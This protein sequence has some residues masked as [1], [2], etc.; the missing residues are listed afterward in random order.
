MLWACH[1]LIC[2]LCLC[3]H[4]HWLQGGLHK[5]LGDVG[6]K[7]TWSNSAWDVWGDNW[8]IAEAEYLCIVLW[9][10]L[11]KRGKVVALT[12]DADTKQANN[13]CNV[14]LT[15]V[16]QLLYFLVLLVSP[17][18]KLERRETKSEMWEKMLMWFWCLLI[19]SS[20]TVL[21]HTI[22]KVLKSTLLK[23]HTVI[24]RKNIL[25]FVFA[26]KKRHLF[27]VF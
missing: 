10:A 21:E 15:C 4:E 5:E 22:M 11:N 26:T 1:R 7:K 2:P 27:W 9:W 18:M 24:G 23:P 17:Y 13:D 6:H 19:I 16:C 12:T 3:K 14:T 25:W 20:T 8:C